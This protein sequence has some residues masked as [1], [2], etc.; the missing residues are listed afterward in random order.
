M[1]KCIR[2]TIE[3]PNCIHSNNIYGLTQK[4]WT[5]AMWP[6][7]VTPHHFRGFEETWFWP[8]ERHGVKANQMNSCHMQPPPKMSQV[9]LLHWDSRGTGKLEAL[10]CSFLWILGP[11]W[12]NVY[13]NLVPIGNQQTGS[14]EMFSFVGLA[15]QSSN[16]ITYTL[17]ANSQQ[18]K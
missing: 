6:N 9:W 13:L 5:T 7:H 18:Y 12:L 15:F 10:W 1:L 14:T 16:R 2:Y 11:T 4:T 8:R 17:M 3:N